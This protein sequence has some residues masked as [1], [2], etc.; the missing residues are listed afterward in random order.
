MADEPKPEPAPATPPPAAVPAAAA[1]PKPAA[2]AAKPPPKPLPTPVFN[3]G[4]GMLL[5]TTRLWP[6]DVWPNPWALPRYRLAVLKLA[7]LSA[8]LLGIAVAVGEIGAYAGPA[9]IF[10]E[11]KLGLLGAP[12]WAAPLAWLA[13]K[14]AIVVHIVILSPIFLVWWE[15]KISA[16]MQSRL[17]PMYVGGFHGWLQTVADGIKLLLK[18]NVTPTDADAW[19]HTLAPAVVVAPALLAFAPVSFGKDLAAADIDVGL[20]Y[21]FAMAGISVV[22]IMMA[23]WGSGNKYSLLGGL[24]SAAQLVSYELPRMFAVVPVI[25]F[26]GSLNLSAIAESQSGYWFNVVPRWYIFYPVVGQLSFLIFLIAS[27]A[28][29]NRTPFDIPEAESELVAGFHTEYSGMKFSLFFLAEYAYMFLAC[30]LASSFFFGGGAAPAWFLEGVLPSWAWFMGKAMTL[31]FVFL[32][33]RWTFPRFRVDRLM[34]FNWKF[35]LPWSFANVALAGV[36][37]MF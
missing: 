10:I 6:T 3:E 22:G 27:V 35:L 18:E 4:S 1:A 30:C 26:A 5:K 12:E 16:H 29:T 11:A 9:R 31:V 21:I 37:V 23:G 32:W 25:M 24:R 2:P 36:Y 19:V 17:G 33:F 8:L 34:D 14:I 20:V 15:R 13:I 7:I 28:E